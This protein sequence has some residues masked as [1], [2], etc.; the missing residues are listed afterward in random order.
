[1]PCVA[2]RDY[3]GTA[4]TKIVA[5]MFIVAVAVYQG[6]SIMNPYWQVFPVHFSRLSI[7]P[8]GQARVVA[9]GWLGLIEGRL[10]KSSIFF[11]SRTF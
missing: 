1:M 4:H 7:N 10:C 3:L 8:R 9:K 6:S 2:Y 11:G 5:P